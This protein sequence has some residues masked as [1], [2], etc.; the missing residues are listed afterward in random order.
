MSPTVQALLG[1]AAIA[2]I[3]FVAFYIGEHTTLFSLG[4]IKGVITH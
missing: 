1:V 4:P 3:A 2:V